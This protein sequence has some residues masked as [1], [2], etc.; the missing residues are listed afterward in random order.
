MKESIEV[1]ILGKP[2]AFRSEF[3]QE[4]MNET[5]KFLNTKMKEISGRTGTV[6]TEKIAVLTAM[7]LAGEVLKMK[8][9]SDRVK[10]KV[11]STSENV[12]K[13]INSLL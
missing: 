10:N 9:E 13:M 3:D 11:K 1:T 6:T 8:T 5:A 2:Y 4:F 7:N 12:L